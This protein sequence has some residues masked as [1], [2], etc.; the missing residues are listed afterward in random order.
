M[1]KPWIWERASKTHTNPPHHQGF[2]S[3]LAK[4]KES[5]IRTQQDLSVFLGDGR[6]QR[7]N[8]NQCTEHLT[9]IGIFFVHEPA[10]SLW[11]HRSQG[12]Q[13]SAHPIVTWC[14][15][16]H[17]PQSSSSTETTR[18]SPW[19]SIAGMSSLVFIK[20]I[21]YPNCVDRACFKLQSK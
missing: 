2:L 13:G 5:R 7:L 11:L 21:W 15:M 10:S 8:C 4:G 6:A 20:K 12:S 14:N 17:C 3:T 9:E 19:Q 18:I 1:T 16:N